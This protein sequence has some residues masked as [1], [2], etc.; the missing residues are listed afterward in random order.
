MPTP[1]EADA[2]RSPTLDLDALMERVR[3]EVN[4]RRDRTSA[5]TASAQQNAAANPDAPVYN[6]DALIA[7]PDAEFVRAA[8]RA[9]FAREASEDEFTGSR[10]RLLTGDIDRTRLLGELLKSDEARARGARIEGLGRHEFGDAIRH[11][12]LARWATNVAHTLRTIYLLPRRIRQFLKRVDG[13][14]RTAGETALAA[15]QLLSRVRALE[16]SASRA[17]AKI[18]LLEQELAIRSGGS[19]RAAAKVDTSLR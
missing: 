19:G 8:Y 3:A 7:L 11:S 10:D 18:A 13:I 16:E 4:A 5:G 12:A 1:P 14:E 2:R 17:D 6:I 15:N 9:I